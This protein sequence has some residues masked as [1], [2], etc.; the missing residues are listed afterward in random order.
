MRSEIIVSIFFLFFGVIDPHLSAQNYNPDIGKD[1]VALEEYVISSTLPVNNPKIEKFFITNYFSTIDNLASRLEGMSLIKRGPYAMEPQL[2]GFSGGQLNITIDGMKMF[3]ACTDKMDPVTSYIEPTNLK[4]ISIQKGA[5]GCQ[6]GCTTGGSID[7]SLSEPNNNNIHKLFSTASY[8]SESV[9]NG[10]NYLFTVGDSKKTLQWA[11][12]AVYRKNDLYTNGRGEKVPFSQF[13][14]SN[15]HLV[16]KYLADSVNRFKTDLLYDLAQNVGYPAL[17]MDVGIARAVL[18]ALEYERKKINKLKLK[19]YYNSIFHV[20]D[21]SKRDSVFYLKNKEN[22][23][24]DLVYMHMDMPGRSSTLGSYIQ[25]DYLLKGKNLLSI[26]LDSYVNHSLAEMTMHMQYPGQAPEFPMYLQTWPE[27]IR[28]ITGIYIQNTKFISNRLIFNTNG[29]ID[30]STDIPQSHFA[31]DQF[32]VLNTNVK[33]D[34]RNFSKGVD[35]GIQYQIAKP[36]SINLETGW[37]ERIPTLGERF[38]FYLFNAYDGYDYIGN[39]NLSTEKSGF[40]KIDLMYSVPS[41]K[42]KFSQSYYMVQDYIMGIRS[43]EIPPMNFYTNGTRIYSNISGVQII[44]YDLQMICNP[45]KELTVFLLTKLTKGKLN[46]GEPL[47]LIAPLKNIISLNYEKH[48]YHIQLEN[49]TSL[50]QDRIN[51]DYGETVTPSFTLFKL[52][53]GNHF[54]FLRNIVDWNIEIANLFNTSYYEHLDWGRI[55]RPGRSFNF[56]IRYSY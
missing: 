32:S 27:M 26:K 2:S 11:F 35:C 24:T 5:K 55:L 46:S 22:G 29:R 20:M 41:L 51:S 15:S 43:N 10:R 33:P 16:I 48:N 36:V 47:P 18:F 23:Q 42:I 13:E 38:G 37:S 21:D 53:A 39:P 31:R 45:V 7:M 3:G 49:E 17:T 19:L 6:N 9:S 30:Y 50:K 12:N 28:N 56:F 40:G 1:T 14:K 54:H 52:K 44:S 34:Y 8:G 25:K 4:S